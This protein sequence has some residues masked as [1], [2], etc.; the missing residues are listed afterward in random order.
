MTIIV[1]I[2]NTIAAT[3]EK[4]DQLFGVGLPKVLE[5]LNQELAA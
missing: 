3:Q 2:R 4:V 5:A 1:M